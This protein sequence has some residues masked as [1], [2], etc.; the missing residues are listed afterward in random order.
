MGARDEKKMTLQIKFVC[1]LLLAILCVSAQAELYILS[2]IT[3]GSDRCQGQFTMEIVPQ[4]PD[5]VEITFTNNCTTDGVITALYMNENEMLSFM[6]ISDKSEGV[7]FSPVEHNAMLPD[8]NKYGF[9]PH[10]TFAI[11]A[12]PA[13]PKNGL[14]GITQP[15]QVSGDFVTL[16]FQL[17]NPAVFDFDD[18]I[19]SINHQDLGIGIHSQSLPGGVSGSFVAVPE[20]ATLVLLGLGT[21][22]IQRKKYGTAH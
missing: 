9:T 17:Q 15:D 8:G 19:N 13:G 21:F 4:G 20:P 16:L 11:K 1:F 12:D 3:S 6:E 5:Q 14:H 22:L 2:K 10:N 7:Y 18:L